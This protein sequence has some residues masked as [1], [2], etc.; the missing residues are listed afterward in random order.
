MPAQEN[1]GIK[2]FLFSIKHTFLL[3]FCFYRYVDFLEIQA[4]ENNN[5]GSVDLRLAPNPCSKTWG[6]WVEAAKYHHQHIETYMEWVESEL[7]IC[8]K[9]PESEISQ[10]NNG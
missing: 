5:D 3:Q 8:S 2:R 4:D 9:P 7:N 10:G 6:K 1:E